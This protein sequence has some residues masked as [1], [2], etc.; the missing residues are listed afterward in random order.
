MKGTFNQ[1]DC[2]NRWI[3]CSSSIDDD[4]EDR[5][6]A[7]DNI[8]SSSNSRAEEVIIGSYRGGAVESGAVACGAQG[9]IKKCRQFREI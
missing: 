6:S 3:V 4:D 5:V 2:E 1:V 7:W 9:S 8:A